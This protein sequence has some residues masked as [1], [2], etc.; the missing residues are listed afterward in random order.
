MMDVYGLKACDTCRKTKK[1]L[2]GAHV[3]YQF[4]DFR[5]DPPTKAQVG[6]W[7]KAV[8]TEKLLNKASTTWRNLPAAEKENI[9]EKKA[10]DLMA[11]HPTLIRRP[12]IERG[13][14][15]VFAGWSK[16]TEAELLKQARSRK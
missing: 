6:R 1:A 13:P 11:A 8:G 9:D 7:A 16:E 5:E 10:I 14:T 2:D 12:I 4:H 15:Q 3:R